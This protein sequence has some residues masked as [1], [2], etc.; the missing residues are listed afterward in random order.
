MTKRPKTPTK[1]SKRPRPYSFDFT[2]QG[3]P[4]RYLLSGIPPTLWRRFQARAKRE[5]IAMRQVILTF[6]EDW[7]S[8]P[9]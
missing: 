6:V 4:K 3:T 8:R 9:E 5:H 1:Q 2:A 7:T